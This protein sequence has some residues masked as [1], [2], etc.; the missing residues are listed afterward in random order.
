MRTIDVHELAENSRLSRFHFAVLACCATI[1]V[2]DGYDLV[3]SGVALPAI[4]RDFGL[5]PA[6]A[7]LLVSTTFLGT[8]CGGVIFGTIADRKGRRVVIASC[9]TI[10]SVSTALAGAADG[11]WAFGVA[12][13]IAGL[14]LGGVMPALL[15]HLAEFSPRR[16][17]N[18]FT[19]LVFT[20]YSV[21]GILAALV[22]KALIPSIGWSSVFY[23]AGASVILVPI[24]LRL[25]PESV[26]H[27]SRSGNSDALVRVVTKLDPS[28][29]HAD[30]D[31]FV[32]PALPTKTSEVFKMLF[33][34]GR[35]LG[36]GML[37]IAFFMALFMVYA[38]SS[39]LAELMFRA[40][41]D[42]GS[43]LT[44]VLVLNVGGMIGAVG[45]GVL[46][47]RYNIR[48]VLVGM[49]FTGLVSISLLG[50]A[51]TGA[52]FILLGLAGATTIGTTNVV[53]ALAAQY[54]PH[55]L[56][57]TGIGLASGVG[58]IGAF[59][60]PVVIGWAVGLAWPPQ[61][62]FFVMALPALIGM[63]VVGWV[64]VRDRQGMPPAPV[65]TGRQVGAA[66]AM[67]AEGGSEDALSP[68]IDKS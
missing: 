54:Y 43:S 62:N 2:V 47:D 50:V 56:R 1:M 35:S 26:A 49:F 7:G 10:F 58:R 48:A 57:G 14:G 55:T 41:H 12:R 8:L 11:P 24:A 60:A 13:F 3:I 63:A 19:T 53:Y 38:L 52:Q 31:T 42:L 59:A 44:F 66:V 51:P 30:S 27:L 32:E 37:W 9:V 23:V 68:Q 67:R 18:T 21:G 22:G 40:G 20:G 45:G 6:A 39:W 61:Y 5:S 25:L 65:P 17:K 15:A 46:G 16:V 28:Y 64:R 4:M 36:T 29:Q 33:T 34:H